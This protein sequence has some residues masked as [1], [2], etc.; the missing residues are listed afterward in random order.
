MLY[1]VIT[2]KRRDP[3]ARDPLIDFTGP[4]LAVVLLSTGLANDR[5][6]LYFTGVVVLA[7]WA[8]FALRP[9]YAPL[10]VWAA[11]FVVGAGAGYAGHVGL[12]QLQAQIE[13]WISDW[14][15]SGSYNFV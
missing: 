4:Y 14:Y 10:A 2:R 15:L 9:R 5:G 6:P 12:T 7:A 1:E 3:A 11:L 8:L 13:S